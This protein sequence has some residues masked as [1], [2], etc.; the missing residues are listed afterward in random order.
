MNINA[1]GVDIPNHFNLIIIKTKKMFD[2]DKP[3]WIIQNNE[4][5][6]GRVVS[7]SDLADKEGKVMGGGWWEYDR[8]SHTLYLYN[9][10]YDYGQVEEDDF[11]DVWVRPSMEDATI[12]FSKAMKLE[13]AKK[14]N[15]LIQDNNKGETI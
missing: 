11:E 10:S 5:R 9:K 6:I 14:N 2:L 15:V 13:D 1:V 4:L 12:Y 8:D 3:K 7:H